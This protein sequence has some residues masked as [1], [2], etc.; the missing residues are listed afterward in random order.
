[1]ENQDFE[2]RYMNFMVWMT[3][4]M[5]SFVGDRHC[6]NMVCSGI[7]T[8]KWS[9]VCILHDE[10]GNSSCVSQHLHHRNAYKWKDKKV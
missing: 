6:V 5:F 8:C 3:Y 7:K 10:S 9:Q 4:E 2:L 1:M